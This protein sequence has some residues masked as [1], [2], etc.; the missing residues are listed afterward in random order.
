MVSPG[1]RAPAHV[2]SRTSQPNSKA[3][4]TFPQRRFVYESVCC[5]MVGRA[6]LFPHDGGAG[7]DMKV[8]LATALVQ[9]DGG[10]S[11][12]GI[13]GQIGLYLSYVIDPINPNTRAMT[14]NCYDS[15]APYA[16]LL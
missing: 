3:G 6:L 12:M 13:A 8:Y 5:R 1:A 14:W 16:T 4:V 2:A 9:S 7:R 11:V 15:S 10:R